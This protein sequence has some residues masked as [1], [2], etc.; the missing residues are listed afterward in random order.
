MTEPAWIETIS[1]DDA[2]EEVA[3]AYAYTGDAKTG[4]VDHIMKVHSLNPQSMLDHENLYKT[5]MYGKGPLKRPQ[6][7]M[8][9]VV[10]S[11]LN[12]CVY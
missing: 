4:N 6:R 1:E 2:D 11:A 12:H 10:V 7:E 5:L 8:I 3:A 9:G